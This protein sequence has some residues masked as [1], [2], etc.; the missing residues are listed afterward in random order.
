MYDSN[1]EVTNFTCT[2]KKFKVYLQLEFFKGSNNM[3][4]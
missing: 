2:D 1:L 4:D 3:N